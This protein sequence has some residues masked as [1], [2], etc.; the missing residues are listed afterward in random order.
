MF[1]TPL[2]CKSFAHNIAARYI[3]A[4]VSKSLGFAK[5]QIAESLGHEYCNRNTG[6][7]LDNY[8]NEIID[9]MNEKVTGNQ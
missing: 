6:I 9:Q 5:D 4:N 3:W 7:Y 2:T 8:G 1:F